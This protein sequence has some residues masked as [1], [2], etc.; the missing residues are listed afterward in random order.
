M[1]Y[2]TLANIYEELSG[3]T[4]RL[5]KTDI[6][7][8]Y[9]KKIPKGNEEWVYLIRGK[10]LPDYDSREFGI[11]RQLIIK[12]ISRASGVSVGEVGKKF[13]RIGDLGEVAEAVM[14]NKKQSVFN[15]VSILSLIFLSNF[16]RNF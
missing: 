11:S 1:K 4:K 2:S 8:N 5:E 12:V 6:L 9:L 7:S 13:N 10:V 16:S 3:T 15:L 14:K